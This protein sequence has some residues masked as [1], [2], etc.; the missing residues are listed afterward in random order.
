MEMLSFDLRGKF[1]HFR[2]YYANNTALSFAIPPRTTVMGIAAAIIGLPR[3]SYHEQLAPDRLRFGVRLLTPVKKSFHRLNLLMIKGA[4]DFRGQKGRVQT[5]FEMVSGLDVKQDSVAYRIYV[6]PTEK[7][8]KVFSELK[9]KIEKKEAGY[10]LSLGPA[11]CLAAMENVQLHL[12]PKAIEGGD[13]FVPV[14]TA[15]QADKV[16]EIDLSKGKLL[17]EEE[18]LPGAFM[19]DYDRELSGMNRVLFAT[20]GQPV[21]VKLEGTYFE[22]MENGVNVN[23]TFLE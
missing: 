21:S 16:R 7:G 9:V 6:S 1:A 13:E 2:K 23:I 10:N 8:R 12:T 11:F 15:V 14:S 3:D 4:P 18:L 5:P 20:D 19:K 17:L 22:L